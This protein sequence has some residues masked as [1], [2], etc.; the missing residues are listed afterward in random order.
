MNKHKS[1]KLSY[2]KNINICFIIIYLIIVTIVV[3]LLNK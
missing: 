3:V 1:V 2:K